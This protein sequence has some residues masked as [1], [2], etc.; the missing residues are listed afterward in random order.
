MAKARAATK[1]KKTPKRAIKKA[2]TTK[3]VAA[4]KKPAPKAQYP[5]KYTST[6]MVAYLAQ[7][8]KMPRTQMKLIFDSVLD[9]VAA[10]VKKGDRVPLGKIGKL[11]YRVRPARKARKGR[12]PSTG[13]EILVPAKR[14]TKVPKFSFSKGFKDEIL[15]VRAKKS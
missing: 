13:E 3:K 4:K 15:K 7:K 11:Y 1:S 5:E 12:N 10:G 9:V 2:V 14:A 8:H 6:S